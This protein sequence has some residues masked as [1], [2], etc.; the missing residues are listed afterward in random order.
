[1]RDF[2]R[3]VAA[4]YLLLCIGTA[5]AESVSAVD[6]TGR[7]IRLAAPAQRI[8][9]L[10][11]HLTETLFAIGVGERIVGTVRYSDHP[12]AA[13]SIPRLGD[14]FSVSIESVISLD[15][16]LVVAWQTG[17]TMRSVRRLIELGV[18]VYINEAPALP[19]IPQSVEAMARLVG[20]AERGR[21][22]AQS[23]TDTL[24]GLERDDLGVD[25]FFQISDQRLYTVDREHLIGQAISL[26]G[27]RNIFSDSK[28]PVPLVS[29][30]AVVSA[31]PDLIVITQ[32]PEAAPSPWF[33]KWARFPALAGKIRP[34]DP[35]LISRPD[36]GWQKA[37]K[38]CVNSSKRPGQ[39]ESEGDAGE[40]PVE[41]GVSRAIRP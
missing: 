15:P 5:A 17:G 35:D 11:P 8:V 40:F 39:R 25:V 21:A 18:P 33:D 23:F 22:L 3:A 4:A 31:E 27:G 6:D 28:I 14:A 10:A 1:M 9:S 7:E 41:W 12:P 34:I 30:E 29:Q 13:K 38:R 26:C 2:A 16:D 20:E 19:D 37:L 24:S 36:C 32:Q